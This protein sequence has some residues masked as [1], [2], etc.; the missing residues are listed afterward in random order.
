MD[1]KAINT[2]R[3]SGMLLR[4]ATAIM[5]VATAALSIPVAAIAQQLKITRA[6]LANSATFTATQTTSP[7]GGKPV[8][9]VFRVEVKGN[10]A[11]LDYQDDLVGQV[12]YVLNEKGAYQYFPGNNSA[13]KASIKGGVEAALKTVFQQVNEQLATAKRIGSATVSGQPTDVFKDANT[14]TLIYV[15]KRPGFRLPVKTVLSN[16][17]GT[18]TLTVSN[19][20]LNVPLQDARFTLPKGAQIIDDGNGPALPGGLPGG[21]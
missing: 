18:N 1:F 3:R 6:S 16:E 21:F 10:K 4:T 11:R 2:L 20:R 7:K 12:R 9:R 8:S 15:G 13:V 14:G 19:I 5:V 17:G